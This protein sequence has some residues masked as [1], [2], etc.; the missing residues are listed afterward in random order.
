MLT[1]VPTRAARKVERIKA[2]V[3]A[4]VRVATMAE[5]EKF[6]RGVRPAGL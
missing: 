6:F 1:R 4:P 2:Y 5:L 3:G